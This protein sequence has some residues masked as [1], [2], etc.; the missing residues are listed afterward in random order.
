MHLAED[1]E[2]WL[3]YGSSDNDTHTM[4]ELRVTLPNSPMA[5]GA[6]AGSPVTKALSP[7]RTTLLP[8]GA[9]PSSPMRLGGEGSLRP[10]A[11][12]NNMLAPQS[13]PKVS[14]NNCN[15]WLQGPFGY[16]ELVHGQRST[17]HISTKEAPPRSRRCRRH[18]G[19]I[20]TST[21]LLLSREQREEDVT[22]SE[23]RELLRQNGGNSGMQPRG[24]A[25][26]PMEASGKESPTKRASSY[27][28]RKQEVS[29][30]Q[31]KLNS[32]EREVTGLKKQLEE[33]VK[34]F[35]ES[36]DKVTKM[37]KAIDQATAD[38]EERK[39]ECVQLKKERVQLQKERVQLQSRGDHY[40]KMA[41][42]N[43]A[44][45]ELHYGARKVLKEEVDQLHITVAELRAAR[46]QSLPADDA[47][48]Y[49]AKLAAANE[50]QGTGVKFMV[51]LMDQIRQHV[52]EQAVSALSSGKTSSDEAD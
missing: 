36:E 39:E 45:A 47:C 43:A 18:R 44:Q 21:S 37:L 5:A 51:S 20:P 4:E 1:G 46:E 50:A 42:D 8:K 28:M 38:M 52:G 23:R 12:K 13:R 16:L 41:A 3:C 24:P 49:K 10:T 32:A 6:A 30:T 31:A 22:L 11:P 9:R 2:T 27:T 33:A 7:I 25:K 15:G 48:I 34:K 29:D 35:K 14:S 19:P 40:K 17:R 26:R